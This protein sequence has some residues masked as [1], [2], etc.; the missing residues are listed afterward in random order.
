MGVCLLLAMPLEGL[1]AKQD[2]EEVYDN[3]TESYE[4]EDYRAD[5]EDSFC[6][7]ASAPLSLAECHTGEVNDIAPQ[8]SETPD[9]RMDDEDLFSVAAATLGG[10]VGCHNKEVHGIAPQRHEPEGYRSA[11]M[12]GLRQCVKN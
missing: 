9:Y 3:A 7:I 6:I 2:I 10:L 5:D 4:P 12:I 8:R 11:S 1:A